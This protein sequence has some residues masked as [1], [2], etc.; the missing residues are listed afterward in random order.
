MPFQKRKQ[1]LSCVK[2]ALLTV[3]RVQHAWCIQCA[4]YL[5]CV[6]FLSALEGRWV[7][8]EHL[9]HLL[10]ACT[11]ILQQVENTF[12]DLQMLLAL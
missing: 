9:Q 1:V 10:D 12:S 2:P 8:I 7:G 11:F 5:Q 4:H 6:H 3:T